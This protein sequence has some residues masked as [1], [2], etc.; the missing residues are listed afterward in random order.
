MHAL[1]RFETNAAR[2]SSPAAF[3]FAFRPSRAPPPWWWVITE[4]QASKKEVDTDGS[5]QREVVQRCE[6]VRF[7][8]PGGRRG[9]VCALQ[10]HSGFRFQKPDRGRQ[11]RVRG[12]A[13]PR[14]SGARPVP[15]PRRLP[16]V[17][18]QNNLDRIYPLC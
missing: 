14:D 8:L 18:A 9:C 6:G 12:E 11:G 16:E 10:R 5:G 1:A 2:T 13:G 4:T 15:T 3:L 7:H 17:G